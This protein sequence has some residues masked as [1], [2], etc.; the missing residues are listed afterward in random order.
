MIFAIIIY[1]LQFQSPTYSWPSA[2]HASLIF[3]DHLCRFPSLPIFPKAAPGCSI[4]S[5]TSFGRF[6][7]SVLP[8]F[9]PCP[10]SFQLQIH[11]RLSVETAVWIAKQ[12]SNGINP[13]FPHGLGELHMVP[14]VPERNLTASYCICLPTLRFPCRSNLCCPVIWPSICILKSD[15]SPEHLAHQEGKPNWQRSKISTPFYK[16]PMNRAELQQWLGKHPFSSDFFVSLF[17]LRAWTATCCFWITCI[18]QHQLNRH[19]LKKFQGR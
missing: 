12:E 6:S 11:C 16:Q 5:C 13:S 10:E 2:K 7:E 9:L 4:R 18:L 14:Q 17:L 15:T 3:F 8:L 1:D 19:S